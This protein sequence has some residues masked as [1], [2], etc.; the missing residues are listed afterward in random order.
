[1]GIE[2]LLTALFVGFH[3]FHKIVFFGHELFPGGIAVNFI[4]PIVTICTLCLLI[5]LQG[6]RSIMGFVA[7]TGL[8]Y[9]F[10]I[11]LPNATYLMLE[12]RHLIYLDGI[13]DEFN[14][15]SYTVFVFFSLAGLVLSI[16]TI[17][18]A[19][20]RLE[21]LSKHFWLSTFALAFLSFWGAMVGFG[22]FYSYHAITKPLKA[23]KI[24]MTTLQLESPQI[25]TFAVLLTIVVWA[26]KTLM[27]RFKIRDPK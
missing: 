26:T 12:I 18:L 27:E 24:A 21:V 19:T 2:K 7:K 14:P 22:D 3:P 8:W 10:L 23:W 9:L 6:K 13:A 1:M 4:W 20:R 5:K 17:L 15:I 11:L 16:H 25:I